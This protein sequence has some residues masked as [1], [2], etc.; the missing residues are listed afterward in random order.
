MAE[1]KMSEA[2]KT[3]SPAAFRASFNPA[4]SSRPEELTV[5]SN[6]QLA[7]SMVRDFGAVATD[8]ALD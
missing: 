7:A 3:P 5:H 1:R 8:C 6:A 4:N 2:G